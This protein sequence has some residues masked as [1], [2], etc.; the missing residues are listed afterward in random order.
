MYENFRFSSGFARGIQQPLVVQ[1]DIQISACFVDWVQRCPQ[2]PSCI[3]HPWLAVWTSAGY[4]LLAGQRSPVQRPR[5]FSREDNSTTLTLTTMFMTATF[6]YGNEDNS[7]N[8]SSYTI[9][10]L[11]RRRQQ[12]QRSYFSRTGGR[13]R[14]S[15]RAALYRRRRGLLAV[16]W[17]RNGLIFLISDDACHRPQVE[18][19]RGQGMTGVTGQG[20][21]VV[22]RAR[23]DAKLMRLHRSQTILVPA[24]P[25]A[26][27]ITCKIKEVSCVNPRGFLFVHKHL[28]LNLGPGPHGAV[29]VGRDS[30]RTGTSVG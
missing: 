9:Q 15:G 27:L 25:S 1:N 21:F 11:P 6:N 19:I 13:L 14:G 18:Y 10:R 26:N 22:G 20:G 24:L 30:P 29:Y 3:G 23:A 12:Q 17:L 7:S 28:S 16:R 4:T 2:E 5:Q 8:N